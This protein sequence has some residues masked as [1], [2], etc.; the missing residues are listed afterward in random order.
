MKKCASQARLSAVSALTEKPKIVEEI[1]TE[2]P[3]GGK[4]SLGA[5]RLP[6]GRQ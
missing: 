6:G 4:V 1:E 3:Q 2:R 5:C